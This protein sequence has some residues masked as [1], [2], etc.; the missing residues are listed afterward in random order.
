[1]RT[2][3]R[4]FRPAPTSPP[5]FCK[6][7]LRQSHG[8]ANKV[9]P[10]CADKEILRHALA[11]HNVPPRHIARCTALHINSRNTTPLACANPKTPIPREPKA[12]RSVKAHVDFHRYRHTL[13]PKKKLLNRPGHHDRRSQIL[14]RIGNCLPPHTHTHKMSMQTPLGSPQRQTAPSHLGI[15]ICTHMPPLT[16]TKRKSRCLR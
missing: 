10:R 15:C 7:I 12:A 3:A 4:Y 6:G 8:R 13:N 5:P 11:T 14:I 9:P 1:M 16:E 2:P